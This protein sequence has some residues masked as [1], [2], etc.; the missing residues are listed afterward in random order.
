M[1]ERSEIQREGEEGRGETNT[2]T[3]RDTDRETDRLR[4][5]GNEHL[6]QTVSSKIFFLR[7]YIQFK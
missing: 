2:D 7:I 6:K 3:E 1:R 4:E 5:R